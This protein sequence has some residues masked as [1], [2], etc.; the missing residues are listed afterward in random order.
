MRKSLLA[1]ALAATVS[2]AGAT[3]LTFDDVPDSVPNWVGAM[4]TYMGYTFGCISTVRAPGCGQNQLDW[5]D[6][7]GSYWNFG[8]VSGEF[9]LL[10]NYGGVGVIKAADNSDFVFAGL[11][12]RVWSSAPPRVGYLR[13]FD[14]GVEV[15]SQTVGL[16][17]TFTQFTGGVGAIDEL[18]LDFGNWFL[19]DNISLRSSVP[20]PGT[21][22]L[23]GLGLAGLAFTLTNAKKR[24]RTKLKE[25]LSNTNKRR[26]AALREVVTRYESQ[27][28]LAELLDWMPSYLSQMIGPHPSRPIGETA[29]RQIEVTLGLPSG[30]LDRESGSK[31]AADVEPLLGRMANARLLRLLY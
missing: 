24:G 27:A 19:A 8:A 29:A 1:L 22:T 7:V 10:N 30:L 3:V 9:T 12:A 15:W 4:P 25:V 28:E 23:L 6:T 2:Q 14:N 18:R 11:W 16:N 20:E 21:F 26:V 17:A 5:I 31:A 13:G